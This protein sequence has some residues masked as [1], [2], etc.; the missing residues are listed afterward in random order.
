MEYEGNRWMNMILYPFGL[1]TCRHFGKYCWAIIRKDHEINYQ[2]EQSI[3]RYCDPCAQSM[4]ELK[5][6]DYRDE[7]EADLRADWCELHPEECEENE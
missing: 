1:K 7:A 3:G 4:D 5:G 6:E 2:F